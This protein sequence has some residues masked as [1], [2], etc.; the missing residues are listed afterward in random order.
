MEMRRRGWFP[1]RPIQLVLLSLAL[2]LVLAGAAGIGAW[3]IYRRRP[4][5]DDGL[6]RPV[7][8]FTLNDI[9]GQPVALKDYQGKKAV[10]LVFMG[11]ECPVGNLYMP[12]LVELS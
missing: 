9:A 5:F 2:A 11:T 12:R 6:G 8:D 10:V 4:T 1:P 3:T 7:V